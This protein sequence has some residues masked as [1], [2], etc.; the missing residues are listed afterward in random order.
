MWSSLCSYELFHC[1]AARCKA[2]CKA[3][4]TACHLRQC[5]MCSF[6]FRAAQAD[7]APADSSMPSPKKTKSL[8]ALSRNRPSSEHDESVTCGKLRWCM[9]WRVV[10]I[11]P[12]FM[13]LYR[14]RHYVFHHICLFVYSSRLI[15]LPRYLMNG[16]SNLVE[17]FRE[18]SLDPSD[19]VAWWCNR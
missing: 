18:Y 19:E 4:V 2:L 17:T 8:K 9:W 13:F 10:V 6:S 15:L 12:F 16:L 11:F 14:C 3:L 7:D 1:N 5:I